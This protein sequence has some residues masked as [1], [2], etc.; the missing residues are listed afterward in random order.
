[1][2][3][4]D[5]FKSMD[6]SWDVRTL[7]TQ[8]LR[9]VFISAV[10]ALFMLGVLTGTMMYDVF[11]LHHFSWSSAMLFPVFVVLAFRCSRLIYRRLG[12]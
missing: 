6:R 12:H 5:S 7:E 2:S 3:L 1:M 10:V 4:F 8:S 9:S 11:L